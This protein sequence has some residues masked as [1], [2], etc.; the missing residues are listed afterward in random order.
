LAP[1]KNVLALNSKPSLTIL[2]FKVRLCVSGNVLD[3][4][5]VRQLAKVPL[6]V[7][8]CDA[9]AHRRLQPEGAADHVEDVICRKTCFD[10]ERVTCFSKE[11]AERFYD[12]LDD[13]GSQ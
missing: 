12:A 3:A 11:I 8:F 1:S 5:Q 7:K 6:E 10:F 4:A 13:V 2:N 9:S